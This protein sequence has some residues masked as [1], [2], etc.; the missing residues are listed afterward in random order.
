MKPAIFAATIVLLSSAFV[1][2][3]ADEAK[4]LEPRVVLTD[5][6]ARLV[7]L[8]AHLRVTNSSDSD[9]RRFVFRVT[10]PPDLDSQRSIVL[11]SDVAPE[12]RKQHKNNANEYLEFHY[13]LH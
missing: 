3:Y 11:S 13:Y 6:P 4:P 8:T 2:L 9:V 7:E 10:V 1:A 12:S 5:K